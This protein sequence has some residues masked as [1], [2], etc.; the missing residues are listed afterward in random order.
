MT[1]NDDEWVKEDGSRSGICRCVCL[2]IHICS[3]A[4]YTNIRANELVEFTESLTKGLYKS[5]YVNGA[6]AD[7]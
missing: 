3:Y 6:M 2:L 4:G 7:T 5:Q 1:V